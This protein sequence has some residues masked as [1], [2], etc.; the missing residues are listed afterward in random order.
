MNLERKQVYFGFRGLRIFDFDTPMCLG[1]QNK[2]VI[3][4]YNCQ[5]KSNKLIGLKEGDNIDVFDR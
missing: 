5:I 2:D 4:V 1:M 3:K